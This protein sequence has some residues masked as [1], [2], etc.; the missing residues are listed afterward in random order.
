MADEEKWKK[1]LTGKGR[2][3]G[4]KNKKTLIKEKFGS[5]W[6]QLEDYI[7]HGSIEKLIRETNKLQG[8]SYVQAWE[9]IAEF[10]VP[11]QQRKVIEHKGNE[12]KTINN[13]LNVLSI[14]DKAVLL[15]QL[16]KA[17]AKEQELPPPQER[18]TTEDTQWEEVEQSEEDG[19][20]EQEE[21]GTE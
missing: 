19:E 12:Q 11:K 5:S 20:E 2:P 1:N 8:K 9:T 6:H 15:E 7:K 21:E 18:E 14:E 4:V 16:R 3:K 13:Y 17:A 10:V